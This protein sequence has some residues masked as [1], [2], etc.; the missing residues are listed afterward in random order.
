MGWTAVVVAL[1]FI[2]S[3]AFIGGAGAFKIGGMMI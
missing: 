2:G 3:V 1:L